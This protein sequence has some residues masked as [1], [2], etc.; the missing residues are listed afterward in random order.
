MKKI[1]FFGLFLFISHTF[2]VGPAV[3]A[4]PVMGV[5]E[6]R[7]NANAY[8]WRSG[9]GWELSD[10]LTNELLGTGKFKMV[11]RKKLEHVLREQNL[12][13]SGRVRAGTA[14]KIGQLTGAKYLVMGTVSSFEKDTKDTGG[15]IGYGGFR[16]GG[17]KEEAYLAID[18]RVVDTSTGEVEFV[19]TVEARAK[20][21][22]FNLG[23]S[24]FGFHG[25]LKQEEKTPTG[26]AIRAVVVE[27]TDYL[28]C[29]MVDKDS[30]MNEYGAKEQRRRD[31]TKGAVDLD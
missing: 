20:A 7:N 13:A 27:A 2:A 15:G 9:V 30:C 18:L 19:R 10:M 12:G 26:K 8:W 11:E 17:K 6:F 1:I 24:K 5:A 16:I 21:S 31:K 28:A 4:K 29:V 22:G 25:N 23:L 3:A 14:A